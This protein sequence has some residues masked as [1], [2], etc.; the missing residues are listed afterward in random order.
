MKTLLYSVRTVNCTLG[1]AITD[2]WKQGLNILH[3][4]ECLPNIWNETKISGH[5]D[6][7]TM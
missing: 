7:T 3:G 2:V 5:V 6:S 4:V 1:S